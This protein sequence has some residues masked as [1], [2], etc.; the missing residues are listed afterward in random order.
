MSLPNQLTNG[1]PANA[2][3]VQE[4]F[5][6]LE[7]Y[8]KDYVDEDKTW[9][10]WT[11]T[12]VGLTVGD[13]VVNARYMRVGRKVDWFLHVKMGSTSVVTGFMTFSLPS[14]VRYYNVADA[15]CVGYGTLYNA[16]PL[17]KFQTVGRLNSSTTVRISV[18]NTTSTY[19]SFSSA[20]TTTPFV[21]STNDRIFLRGTYEIK[22]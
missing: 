21:W 13:A 11:P 6:F 7:D 14:E 19:A 17:E 3:E 22:L 10:D 1:K 20:G 5:D 9:E 18:I 16:A 15:H 2:D 12:W 8:F 4:N